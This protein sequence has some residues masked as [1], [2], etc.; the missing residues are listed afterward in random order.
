GGASNPV[1]SPPASGVSSARPD[2]NWND[3][4]G[5]FGSELQI[6]GASSFFQTTPQ[7]APPA[8]PEQISLADARSLAKSIVDS[9]FRGRVDPAMLTAMIEIE[10]TFRPKAYRYER[11]IGDASYGLMQVLYGTAKWLHDDMG[12]RAYSLPSGEAMYDPATGVYFGAAYVDYL[13]GHPWA[14]GTTDWTVMSYN[15]GPGANNAQT[16][17]H[18]AKYRAARAAQA[19]VK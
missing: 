8:V 17:N 4:F 14:D 19:K 12:Y 9:H 7:P 11:H 16:R 1:A 5:S 2:T 18:L 6:S 13:Q 3:P 10:S 15:G